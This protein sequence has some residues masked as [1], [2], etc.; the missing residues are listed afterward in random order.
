MCLLKARCFVN[1]EASAL[2]LWK[3]SASGRQGG[4]GRVGHCTL[5]KERQRQT[6]EEGEKERRRGGRVPASVASAQG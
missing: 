1:T 3:L 6:E 4:E 5:V 2:T